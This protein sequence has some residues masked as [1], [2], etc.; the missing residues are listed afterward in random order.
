MIRLIVSLVLV[1]LVLRSL[2]KLWLGIVEG[3]QGP[4]A[5]KPKQAVPLVR[6]PIC[7]TYV[8]P[9][10]A[11]SSGTGSQTKFFCSEQCRRSYAMKIAQ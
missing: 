6:D 2:I 5:P 11:L 8:V 9:S 3:L 7:G 10:K 4:K 1:A